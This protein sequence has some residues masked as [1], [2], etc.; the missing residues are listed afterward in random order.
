M[1]PIACLLALLPLAVPL[2]VVT[3]RRDV[4]AFHYAEEAPIHTGHELSQTNYFQAVVQENLKLPVWPVWSGL[5]LMGVR[6][7][8]KNRAIEEQILRSVGGRVVPIQ[9]AGEL[10]NS[11]F[12]LLAHHTHSFTPFDPT[13]LLMKA[14][15]PEGFP[16]H[17]HSGFDTVTYCIDGGLRHRDSEGFKMSYG[18]GSTQWMR[19]GRGTI[20]EEMWDLEDSEYQHKRIELFQIWVNLQRSSK[21]QAPFVKLLPKEAVPILSLNDGASCKVVCGDV[22]YNGEIISGPGTEV[23]DS[24]VHILH[25]TLPTPGSALSISAPGDSSICVYVRQGSLCDVASSGK[26]GLQEVEIGDMIMYGQS[27]PQS[28]QHASF[29]LTAGSSGADV[30][31]L[32]G[33]P[34]NE[35]VVM[36]GPFVAASEQDLVESATAFQV[37]GDV[38][39]FWEH[40]LTD[41]DWKA[42]CARLNLQR[43]LK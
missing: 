20:H 40:T 36:R 7:V 17:P 19:A 9:F 35:P 31:L 13:R 10:S 8:L 32:I 2:S 6:A 26:T 24:S 27:A 23:A 42:H 34:L 18:D 4:V 25:L 5:A 33:K 30:L 41:D 1:L 11:P 16:A 15:L 22:S 28:S 29:R 39:A 3:G 21:S 38:G 37:A 12:L 14:I 43:N